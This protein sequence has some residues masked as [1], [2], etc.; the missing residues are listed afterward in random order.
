MLLHSQ[1]AQ[2]R[3][4]GGKQTKKET[5]LKK[6]KTVQYIQYCSRS[7]FHQWKL[8]F[9]RLGACEKGEYVQTRKQFNVSRML[10]LEE[11]EGKGKQEQVKEDETESTDGKLVVRVWDT[12]L[13]NMDYN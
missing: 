1:N 11:G 5:D 3:K 4:T 13:R 8:Y 6:K 2:T 7:T 10:D 12:V 9:Q